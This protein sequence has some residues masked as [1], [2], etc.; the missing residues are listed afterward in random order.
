MEPW[1]FC[2]E[3]GEA[4]DGMSEANLLIATIFR[5][6]V[7]PDCA[8]KLPEIHSIILQGT[9]QIQVKDCC[10][11]D[12]CQLLYNIEILRPV[13]AINLID[14][15]WQASFIETVH[16]PLCCII[17]VLNEDV[18]KTSNTF[19]NITEIPNFTIGGLPGFT[20]PNYRCPP[21]VRLHR[22]V[23]T[24]VKAL[25]PEV[26]NTGIVGSGIGSAMGYDPCSGGSGISGN[27]DLSFNVDGT[28][29][30]FGVTNQMFMNFTGSPLEF[31][32]DFL[33]G[34]ATFNMSGG[35]NASASLSVQLPNLSFTPHIEIH[36]DPCLSQFLPPMSL[37]TIELP[38]LTLGGG[39]EFGIFAN[40]N[41]LSS[42]FGTAFGS[43]GGVGE[44]S[45]GMGAEASVSIPGVGTKHGMNADVTF[46]SYGQ[47]R[48]W[49]K[50]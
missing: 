5:N 15:I 38:T 3:A 11:I 20:Y 49:S 46:P 32:Y 40:S 36:I 29:E 47:G 33:C 14:P 25:Y 18:V 21:L 43:A 48:E 22:P 39:A 10:D 27:I 26:P 31:L 13:T 37:P 35:I 19:R 45:A 6:K 8:S 24:D 30:T 2:K 23:N 16:D 44:L 41:L 17:R 28:S 4:M 9:Q 12:P 1:S 42:N 50:H 34:G 7:C